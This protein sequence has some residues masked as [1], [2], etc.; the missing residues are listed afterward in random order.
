[1]AKTYKEIIL[2]AV[3]VILGAG[4]WWFLKHVFYFGNLSVSYWIIGGVIFVLWGIALSLA[5]LLIKDK[6]ILYGSF[7]VVAGAFGM[8]FNNEPFYYLVGLVILFVAFVIGSAKIKRE[9]EVQVKLNFFR[10][11]KRGLPIFVTALALLI[12]MVYYFSPVL[13]KLGKQEIIIP[14]NIFD[15]VIAPFEG[16]IKARLPQESLDLNVKAV[17]FLKP[18]EISDLKDKY[19]IVITKDETIRDLLYQFTEYQINSA[20]A[21]YEKFIPIGL[22]IALFLAL[23]FIGIF[24]VLIAILFTWLFLRLLI[25]LKF[26]SFGKETKEVET[27]R[28]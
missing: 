13:D 17:D 12:A 24:Y 9:E 7:V 4:F 15:T 18:Q 23:K 8:F 1:M 5:M 16:L 20:D 26:V 27:V 14:R 22:A 6:R 10:I 2:G 11:W 3:V 25:V 28:L 19:N 21:P